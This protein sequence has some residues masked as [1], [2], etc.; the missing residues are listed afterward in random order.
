MANAAQLYIRDRDRVLDV[1]CGRGIFWKGIDRLKIDLVTNDLVTPTDFHYDFRELGFD[2]GSF[3][4]AV[5]D[6]PYMHDGARHGKPPVRRHPQQL[7]RRN[8]LFLL[9]FKEAVRDKITD[10][11]I[12]RYA[13]IKWQTSRHESKSGQPQ[14]S[15]RHHHAW[16][17]GI[18]AGLSTFGLRKRL[19]GA[20]LLA[21]GLLPRCQEFE[22]IIGP[23]RHQPAVAISLVRDQRNFTASVIHRLRHGFV[24][25]QVLDG[26]N[27]EMESGQV[28]TDDIGRVGRTRKLLA[29][30]GAKSMSDQHVAPSTFAAFSFLT[31]VHAVTTALAQNSWLRCPLGNCK[32]IPRRY[33]EDPPRQKSRSGCMIRSTSATE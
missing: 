30:P 26:F 5:F 22:P 1:T 27:L 3:D 28:R 8:H 17:E 11:L 12:S 14:R 21:R 29:A 18:A 23:H 31:G 33:S 10:L 25:A 24:Q 9:I 4:R 32:Q 2:A 16:P 20:V 6:P 19:R 13:A 7:A 15:R